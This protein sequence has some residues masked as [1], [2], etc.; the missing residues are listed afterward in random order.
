MPATKSGACGAAACAALVPFACLVV[1]T[2]ALPVAAV[3]DGAVRLVLV[4][5]FGAL[6]VVAIV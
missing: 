1:A 3:A 5:L 6:F 4:A 2:V